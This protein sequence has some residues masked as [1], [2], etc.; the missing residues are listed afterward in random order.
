MPIQAK[1]DNE[2]GMGDSERLL[3]QLTGW[4]YV[5]PHDSLRQILLLAGENLALRPVAVEEAARWLQI[6]VNR[7]VGRLR[8]TELIQLARSLGDHWRQNVPQDALHAR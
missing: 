3:Q 4:Q 5:R 8:R 1:P 2:D 6:D 7:P